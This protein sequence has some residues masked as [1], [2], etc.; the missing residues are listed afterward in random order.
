MTEAAPQ[1]GEP[2][3]ERIVVAM[4][5]GVDSSVVAALLH[6]Q[7]FQVVGVSMRLYR[8]QGAAA[9]G[10]CSPDDLY[11][12]RAVAAGLG[13]P[14]YVVNYEEAFE[15]R[16]IARFVADY[17]AGRTPSP[18]VLCNN[19]LKFETLLDRSEQLGAARLATGHYA[20]LER[21]ADG[22][23]RL[24]RGRDR[25]KDQ[26]YF[27]FGIGRQALERIAFPLGDL[28]KEEVRALAQ[29]Y[30]LPTAHK[31]ESQD[32]CFVGGRSYLE[33]L[34]QRLPEEARRPGP[35][36]HAETGA[37]LGRHAGIHRFTVGQRR[38]L[39]VSADQPLYVTAIS[40]A[41]GSV[42]VGPRRLTE[43]RHCMLTGCSWLAFDRLEAP[44]AA[45]VQVRYRH[46][47]VPAVV[48]PVDGQRAR[49]RFDHPEPAVAP[50]QAAVVYQGDEVLGGGWID[51][52]E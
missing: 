12:A 7:G 45:E 29:R 25:A 47:A 35:I 21:A 33:F 26:S 27:L 15:A 2:G 8:T 50:G 17:Q 39:G 34:E 40:A 18:C 49:L 22:R 4:S 1:L 23:M 20:R 31:P 14:F 3:G 24:L 28:T 37:V 43:S 5:G 48:E 36:Q 42:S 41:D 9:R 10:C 16:V 11:D 13:I 46:R 38:G 32:L 30:G 19:H 44:L 6:E 52:R 51:G